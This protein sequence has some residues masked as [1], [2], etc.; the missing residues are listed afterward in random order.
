MSGAHET[1][2]PISNGTVRRR[3][4]AGRSRFDGNIF[5]KKK[6]KLKLCETRDAISVRAAVNV[7]NY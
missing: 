1:E 7:I 6:E 4:G 5:Q 2:D 3:R